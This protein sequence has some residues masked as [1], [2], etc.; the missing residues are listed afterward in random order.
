MMYTALVDIGY[1]FGFLGN[2]LLA[3]MPPERDLDIDQPDLAAESAAVLNELREGVGRILA[4]LPEA[5]KQPADLRRVLDLDKALSWN[6]Y[7]L[8]V[9]PDALAACPF[10]PGSGMM[11]R[12]LQCAQDAGV[13]ADI[14]R[15]VADAFSRFEQL[16]KHHAQDRAAF[17][18]MIRDLHGE[19]AGKDDLKH[20]RA[21]YRASRHI[22]GVH[23]D[24][25]VNTLL[26]HPA[27]PKSGGGED[28]GGM[29]IAIVTGDVGVQQNRAR[30]T[31][32]RELVL[33]VREGSPRPIDATD[34]PLSDAS[35]D[36]SLLREFCSEPLP[37]FRTTYDASN[38]LVT[39]VHSR[40]LGSKGASTYF[41]ALVTRNMVPFTHAD[42]PVRVWRSIMSIPSELFQ[43]DVWIHRSLWKH[44][45]PPSVGVYWQRGLNQEGE[46]VVTDQLPVD[47]HVTE[48]VGPARFAYNTDV[49]RYPE[50]IR[51][52]AARLGWEIDDFRLFRC[53]I[54]YPVVGS[55]VQFNFPT[56]A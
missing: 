32:L 44:D 54:E 14:T 31:L 11:R 45:T 27:A 43:R 34:R 35:A 48:I 8:A 36:L 41:F 6:V 7:R 2:T 47:E 13:S 19:D 3:P 21:A 53:R 15:G 28:E 23:A 51:H 20:K 38:R 10:V 26:F 29:D 39:Q 40:Q 9:A 52:V 17:N 25:V 16:V 46:I 42:R 49:P 12:F 33:R 24:A 18:S 1:E 56:G 37:D 50:M 5:V 4:A 22:H 30:T 55:I